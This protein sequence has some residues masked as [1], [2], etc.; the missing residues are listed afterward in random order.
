MLETDYLKEEGEEQKEFQALMQ[1]VSTETLRTIENEDGSQADNKKE[2]LDSAR[3]LDV[4]K[5][6]LGGAM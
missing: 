1:E 4:L 2:E 5:Q 6:D 3:L